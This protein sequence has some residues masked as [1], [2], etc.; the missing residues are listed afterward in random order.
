[1][2]KQPR[3]NTVLVTVEYLPAEPKLIHVNVEYEESLTF[4]VRN[5]RA[6]R[7]G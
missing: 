6:K 1:M 4:K 2:P 3:K 7:K 5:A